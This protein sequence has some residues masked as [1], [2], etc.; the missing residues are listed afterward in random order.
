MESGLQGIVSTL[1]A[2][3]GKAGADVLPLRFEHTVVTEEH[4]GGWSGPPITDRSTLDLGKRVRMEMQRRREGGKM[5]IE[6]GAVGT[7]RGAQAAGEGHR[8]QR[9]RARARPG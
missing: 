4:S 7:Q 3:L 2:P 8:P 5:V 1:P 9:Q 6:R